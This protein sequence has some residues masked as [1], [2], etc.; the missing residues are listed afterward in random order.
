MALPMPMPERAASRG[1]RAQ[2]EPGLTELL[3]RLLHSGEIWFRTELQLLWVDA[4]QLFRRIATGIV[5]LMT[6][7]ALLNAALFVLVTALVPLLAARLGSAVLAAMLV[8][9]GLI[10][11]SA[12]VLAAAWRALT[13]RWNAASSPARALTG[14]GFKK[15]KNADERH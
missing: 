1:S 3:S 11:A 5:L 7:F 13:Q 4:G 9:A 14:A 2:A 8:G 15:A 10:L 12:L 6:A